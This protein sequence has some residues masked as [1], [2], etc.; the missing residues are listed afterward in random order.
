VTS[1]HFSM[2][3]YTTDRFL[4]FGFLALLV[5]MVADTI[6]PRLAARDKAD[7]LVARIYLDPNSARLPYRLFVPHTYDSKRSYPLIV[8]LHGGA[9]N[10]ADNLQQIMG[11]NTNGSHVWIRDDVQREYPAF[12][13]AP[14]APDGATWGGPEGTE[15][16]SAAR[17]MLEIVENLRHEFNIDKSRLYLTGQSLGGFGTWDVIIRRPDVFAAA[18]P[19]CGSG[20]VKGF[21]FRT[22]YAPADFEK[23]RD[24]P[25]WVFQGEDDTT[26][27]PSGPR[28]TVAALRKVG[29]NVRYTEYPGVG[30][31][32]WERAYSDPKLVAWLFAQHRSQ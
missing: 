10:G 28:Q 24:L 32:V 16:S 6:V 29:S 9:G 12:V 15:L 11:G 2:K 17:M 27:P 1:N 8:F 13:L 31:R 18:V 3:P 5:L 25:I 19:L 22:V 26:V 21:P 23:I 30:H 14:Q 4:W 20:I 7:G